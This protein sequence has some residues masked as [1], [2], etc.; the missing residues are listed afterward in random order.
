MLFSLRFLAVSLVLALAGVGCSDGTMEA[1]DSPRAGP[2]SGD[3]IAD[4]QFMREE[5]KL[6]RDVYL[7]LRDAWGVQVFA[8]ISR[9]EQTHTDAVASMIEL[10]GLKDPVVDD[11]VGIF[12][13]PELAELYDEMVTQGLNSSVDALHAGATIEEVDM[14]DIQ[15]AVDRADIP[16][17]IGLYESLLCGSRNHLRAFTSHLEDAGYPYVAQFLDPAEVEAI[18]PSPRE[19]CGTP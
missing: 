19:S 11:T 17:I 14:I 16:G 6:A 7:V 8:N 5:E 9:S 2:A 10:L 4:L 1:Q 15:A 18:V 12:V 3:E 13:D